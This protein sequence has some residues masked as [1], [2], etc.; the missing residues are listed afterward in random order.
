[1][2]GIKK[3]KEGENTTEPEISLSLGN[4]ACKD[5]HKMCLTAESHGQGAETKG[6]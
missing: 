6:T 3:E 4:F 5:A 1:M 2:F